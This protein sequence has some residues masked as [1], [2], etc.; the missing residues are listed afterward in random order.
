MLILILVSYMILPAA[1]VAVIMC[2][3]QFYVML[4]LVVLLIPV[5]Q[6]RRYLFNAAGEYLLKLEITEYA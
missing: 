5:Y 1:L 4:F 3:L 6:V 2:N